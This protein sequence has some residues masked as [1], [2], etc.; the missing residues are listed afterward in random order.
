MRVAR[1]GDAEGF[2]FLL[3]SGS[4]LARTDTSG[5]VLGLRLR[6]GDGE[7]IALGEAGQLRGGL[8]REFC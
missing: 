8:V 7:C 3:V 1:G 2:C 5:F 4:A 6:H